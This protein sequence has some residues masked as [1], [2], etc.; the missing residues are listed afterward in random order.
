MHIRFN[1]GLTLVLGANGLGKTTLVMML[2]R[3]LTGPWDIP[4]LMK[5][6]LLGTASLEAKVLRGKNR[7]TF[8]NRV[9]DNAV[10]ASARLA[11]T[12]GSEEVVVERNIGNLTLRSFTI[13]ESASSK[14]EK[15]YQAEVARLAN[16]S[17]FSDWILLL[18][19]IVFYFEDRRSLVWDPSAQRQLLRILFLDPKQARQWI[20]REREILRLDTLVRN[21]SAVAYRAEKD[22]ARDESLSSNE[23]AT[24]EELRELDQSQ[25]MA[26]VAL[27]D[28]LSQLPDIEAR[29]ESARLRYLTVEQERESQY[30]E[31]ERAHLLAF[32]NRLPRHSDSARYILAQLVT[33]AL[34]LV[35][36][37]HVPQYLASMESRIRSD[38]C[39]I[40]G[41]DMSRLIGSAPVNGPDELISRG[42]RA[43]KALDV[44]LIGAQ[45]EFID[46][47]RERTTAIRT[48]SA[49]EDAITEGSNRIALL[50]K[51]L[52]PEESQMRKRRQELTSIRARAEFLR[53]DLNR[54]RKVFINTI[55]KANAVVKQQASRVQ[56]AFGQYAQEF[57]LED[58]HLLWA[59]I[60]AKLG[61][62]GQMFDFPAFGLELGGSDFTG[63]VRRRGPDDVSQSQKEFIDL[64]FRMALVRVATQQEA[65]SLVMDAPES[66]LDAVFEARA[67]RIL[68][69]FGR[70][71][72]GNR[73]ILT[74]NI[75]SGNI[76]P[77]L[78]RTA[79]DNEH[80]ERIVDLLNI[81]APT[82]AV[83][84]RSSE[85]E[86]A[87]EGL[88][89]QVARNEA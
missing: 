1:P 7:S 72:A 58:G 55:A 83:R 33:E 59:P 26:T 15:L 18:R 10:E 17:T 71:E 48:I 87:K 36:G 8:A 2:Y 39:V 46:S 5:G 37:T 60:S 61:Q 41:S 34:C 85:Y 62:T 29:H 82:A 69:A 22:L 44:E 42:S 47:E 50:L 35:C 6:G 13:G 28:L 24:R 23:L 88:L 76:I 25:E 70:P 12:L 40:C 43:L 4:V 81:A 30:R 84:S 31:L 52:P 74:M 20:D 65:T 32:S 86:N 89:R 21:M 78:L 79:V 77:S 54:K 80:S 56:R 57:L 45:K 75:V 27:D 3:M 14:D 19:Y 68:G 9:A 16:V 64:S 38:H 53:A 66:S 63:T 11:F 73:L 49:L 67:T 51:R